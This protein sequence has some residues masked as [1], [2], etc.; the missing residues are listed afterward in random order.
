MALCLAFLL[1]A[2]LALHMDE[3]EEAEKTEIIARPQYVEL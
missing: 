2:L 1:D 3:G